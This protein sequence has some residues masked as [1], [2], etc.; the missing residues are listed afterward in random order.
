[1]AWGGPGKIVFGVS[2]S[3]SE[4]EE[5]AGPG[6]PRLTVDADGPLFMFTVIP[7]DIFKFFR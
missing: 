4:I 1:L 5:C 7:K 3:V 2:Y 6:S